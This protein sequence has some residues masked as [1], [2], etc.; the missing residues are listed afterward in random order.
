MK[1][2]SMSTVKRKEEKQAEPATE[3]PRTGTP[4]DEKKKTQRVNQKI[5]YL[6]ISAGTVFFPFSFYF[7]AWRWF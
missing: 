1:N 6:Y 3:Q 7:R 2:H 5:G 4:A